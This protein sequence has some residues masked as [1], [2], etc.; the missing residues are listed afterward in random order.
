MLTVTDLPASAELDS[1]A[2]AAVS[3]GR[4][5]GSL[6]P[7]AD[8]DVNINQ[9]IGQFQKI[10]IKLLNDIG[11]LGADLGPLNFNVSPQQSAALYAGFSRGNP[12]RAQPV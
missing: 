5:L 4:S 7:F 6:G 2:M 9:E 8:I 1:Q 10:D 11:V 12:F 3:G